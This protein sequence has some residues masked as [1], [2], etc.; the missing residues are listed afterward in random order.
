MFASNVIETGEPSAS[1]REAGDKT[2]PRQIQGELTSVAG[3][4]EHDGDVHVNGP[5]R[6]GAGIRAGGSV[7][8][9]GPI[10]ST[11][12]AKGDVTTTAAIT[13]TGRHCIVA[14]GSVRSH[15]INTGIVQAKGDVVVGAEII[16][17]RINCRGALDISA[18]SIVAS[19]ISAVGG[20]RCA[21]VGTDSQNR[22][23]LE[24]GVDAEL[25]KLYHETWQEIEKRQTHV[26]RV[27]TTIEPLMQN[28]KR[29]TNEQKEKATELLYDADT[30]EAEA[31]DML[32][33][34]TAGYEALMR[35]G[36]W[37]LHVSTRLAPGVTIRF[38]GIET[39]VRVPMT[40]PLTIT[41]NW[42]ASRPAILCRMGNKNEIPMETR[43]IEDDGI[44]KL[45]HALQR[46]TRPNAQ[47]A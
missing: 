16:S 13:N 42:Q 40:G 24:I 22:V 6:E 41:A 45:K 34:L 23:T 46:R 8:V 39:T 3:V 17:S 37:E 29:L 21:S 19:H 28:A 33:R 44:I 25:G 10:E 12:H 27:R 35:D 47:A 20:V 18:G 7:I 14:G 30:T 1:P 2:V 9:D 43:P 5:V 32:A 11:I 31:N 4:I 38:P 15:H 36:K 26:K